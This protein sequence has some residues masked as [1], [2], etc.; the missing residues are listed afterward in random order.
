MKMEALTGEP[1][2]DLIKRTRLNK[3]AKLIEA[4][5]A[6]TFQDA[7]EVGFSSQPYFTKCFKRQFGLPPSE[8]HRP[9]GKPHAQRESNTQNC[10][11]YPDLL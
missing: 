3:A 5:F 8:Y 1:P 11:L 2:V 7:L 4:G 9:A 6:N 10:Q